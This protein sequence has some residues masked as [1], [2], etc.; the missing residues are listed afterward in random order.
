MWLH[1]SILK[2]YS[3][4]CFCIWICMLLS[5]YAKADPLLNTDDADIVSAKHCQL[6]SAVTRPSGSQA[7][8]QLNTAC[9]FIEGIESSISYTDQFVDAGKGQ[10]S[11]QVKGV[12]QPMSQ[13][14]MAASLQISQQNEKDKES[15]Q[16]FLNI[17]F[18]LVYLNNTL[19]IDSNIGYQYSPRNLNLLRWSLASNLALTPKTSVSVETYNQDQH[20]PLL[21][22]AIHYS[23]L[24]NILTFEASIGQR[25]N[26]FRER[27]FGF[28]LSF[29]P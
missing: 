5:Q 25:L 6:E 14:G 13:W 11:A 24:P 12:I 8:Y 1:A 16:W 23:I 15:I 26:T 17:P 4:Q 20:A 9:Q 19:H 21:Q 28:G 22:G 27:W 7:S 3:I 18:S 29:T 10:W 2:L